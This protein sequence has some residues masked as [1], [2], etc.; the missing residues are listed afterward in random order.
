[1]KIRYLALALIMLSIR[2]FAQYPEVSIRDIQYQNPDSLLTYFEDDHA[3]IYNGDTVTTIGIVMTAPYQGANPDSAVLMY[4]GNGVLSVFLQ[5]TASKT[6][7]WS[8]IFVRYQGTTG[9]FANLDTGMVIKVTGV[10]NE[11]VSTTQKTTQ[12]D[13]IGFDANN[14]LD[15]KPRPQPIV[16]TLDSLKDPR[17]DEPIPTAEKWEGVYVEI[18]DVTTS[19]ATSSGGFTI[20]DNSNLTLNIGTKSDYYYQHTAPLDNTKLAYIRGYFET[21]SVGSNGLTLNPGY[22]ND[23]KISTYPPAITN[24][25]RDKAIVKGGQSVNITADITDQDGVVAGAKLYYRVNQGSLQELTMNNTT[26]NTWAAT[27]PAQNDSSLVDYFIWAQDDSSNVSLSPSDTSRNRDF[28]MVFDRPLKIQDVEY[29]PFTGGYTAYYGYQ[30]TVTGVVTSDTSDFGQVYIQDGNSPWSGIRINGT[31]A[32]KLEKGDNVTV[33]GTVGESGVTWITGLDDA[34]TVTVNSTGNDLPAPVELSTADID[35]K[36]SGTISA[37]E[38]EGVLVKYSNVTVTEENADGHPGIDQ[39]SG[40]NRNFGEMYVN[41]GTEDTRVLLLGGSAN[42]NNGWDS[43]VIKDPN[44]K[45]VKTGAKFGSISGI[46]YYSYGNYKLAPRNDADFTGFIPTAVKENRQSQ[47]QRYE[48]SQNYPNPFN[49]STT[50]KYDIPQGGLVKLQVYN[51]LGQ[52][53][54]TLVNGYQSTG[55]HVV[56]FDASKLASGLY[57][58]KLTSGNFSSVK[59]M[60][61]LK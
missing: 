46:L 18:R 25:L 32:I 61:L 41:D 50:I 5:D 44:S 31:E 60:L 8:G 24:I 53:V 42:Y 22:P 57:L 49:P 13:L 45:N 14:V 11:Y 33:T 43:T 17:T 59:K 1:M 51:I 10:V 19:N 15:F 28:Y 30:V 27:I 2:A 23:L 38:W 58:Y 12:L 54:K 21:R 3:S 37:E 36:S 7:P 52:L 34:S 20:F 29:S 55:Q 47:P 26:D 48:L 40:G 16:L 56:Q 6:A 39:G 9:A 4:G 35:K